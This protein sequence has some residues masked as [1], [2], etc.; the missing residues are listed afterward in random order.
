MTCLEMTRLDERKMHL[1]HLTLE[2]TCLEKTCLEMTCLERILDLT[3]ERN[4]NAQ[5]SLE[6][7][8][9]ADT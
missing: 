3:R 7:A 4:K 8:T 6:N 5:D 9:L 2:M 1:T